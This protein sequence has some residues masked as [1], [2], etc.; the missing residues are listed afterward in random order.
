[1]AIA[2]GLAGLTGILGTLSYTFLRRKHGLELTG[3]FAYIAEVACLS[4]CV[5]SLFAPGTL[6]APAT[7]RYNVQ[8]NCANV[9][10]TPA[11]AIRVR[12]FA[13]VTVASSYAAP[14]LT[15][16]GLLPLFHCDID[17]TCS[18]SHSSAISHFRSRRD[19]TDSNVTGSDYTA[20]DESS[21]LQTCDT[22]KQ[23]E[24]YTSVILFLVGIVTSRVG[25]PHPPLSRF[26]HLVA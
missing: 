24:S 10:S 21:S 22:S 6:F 1:M 18:F 25:K 23:V 16:N 8:P 13:D 26:A 17:R 4:L 2:T 15:D 7:D 3:V 20:T 12:R 9:T 19:V 5:V 14:V 11:T